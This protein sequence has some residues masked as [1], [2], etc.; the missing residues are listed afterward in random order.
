MDFHNLFGKRTTSISYLIMH[1]LRPV[2][3]VEFWS[4]QMQF[5]QWVMKLV[6]LLSIVWI[7]FDATKIRRM[8]RSLCLRCVRECL[9]GA[10]C[11][12]SYVHCDRSREISL[13]FSSYITELDQNALFLQT[14]KKTK[15]KQ[16][17]HDIVQSCFHP[18]WTSWYCLA[19]HWKYMPK[20][21]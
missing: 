11:M 2:S 19:V 18:H 4:H 12:R 21:Q 3:Y 13:W 10:I 6:F 15:K 1:V 8:K 16:G 9:P 20:H 5:K 17:Q 14:V 7:A